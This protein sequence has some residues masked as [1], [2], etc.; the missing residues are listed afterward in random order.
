MKVL[1]S[2]LI[3]LFACISLTA[4]AMTITVVGTGLTGLWTA[5]SICKDLEDQQ[6]DESVDLVIIGKWN[7]LSAL[8]DAS[9]NRLSVF[10]HET[11]GFGPIGI[12]PHSGLLWNTD[13]EVVDLVKKGI[14][15]PDAAFYTA[16]N[17]EEAGRE[18]LELYT[19]W[20]A[21][22]PDQQ[23]DPASSFHRQRALVAIHRYA[24]EQW[25]KFYREQGFSP[26]NN[27]LDFHLEGAWRIYDSPV[28]FANALNSLSMLEKFDYGAEAVGD[29]VQL[30]E[31]VPFYKEAILR[32][33][34]QGIYFRDDGLINS[35]K[36]R[37]YLW[38]FL[39]GNK[40]R[41]HVVTHLDA[42]VTELIIDADGNC[43]GVV[44][45]NEARLDSNVTIL[46][47]GLANRQL[48]KRYGVELPLWSV[49]GAAVQ[50]ELK[51]EA[52]PPPK[53]GVSF[54]TQRCITAAPDG[55]TMIV[56]GTSMVV[57]SGKA[58]CPCLYKGKLLKN[59][60]AIFGDRVNMASLKY[61]AAPRTG[62]ADDLPVIG[63]DVPGINRLLVLNPTSHLGN[64]QSIA[65]GK[66]T[67]LHVLHMMGK[68]ATYP[69]T[70]DLREYRLDRFKNDIQQ[71]RQ[72]RRQGRS[73]LW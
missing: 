26:E 39:N 23:N 1:K 71:V 70:L 13:N 37:L 22:H 27:P 34:K 32:D 9:K 29:S 55:K 60:A 25:G 35:N 50:G 8:E 49:W 16:P 17:L 7:W 72:D 11:S 44:L 69:E 64:T 68:P 6:L 36:L 40:S 53:G 19:G 15:V 5:Y 54:H 3:I 33:G 42:E 20:H 52:G 59:M 18:F 30:A 73:I 43:R 4:H 57:N 63:F 66:L 41:T 2:F 28:N 58:P 48:L 51:N 62:I 67:S 56:A 21:R 47:M 38:D 24:R 10:L 46:A 14:G 45:E 31:R 61:S 65:L 12:Q